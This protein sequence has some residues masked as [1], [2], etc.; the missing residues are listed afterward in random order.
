MYE[1]F[2]RPLPKGLYQARRITH[3]QKMLKSSQLL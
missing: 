3:W 1:P 2:L